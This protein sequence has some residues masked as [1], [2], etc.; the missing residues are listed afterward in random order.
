MEIS[1]FGS[2]EPESGRQNPSDHSAKIMA[3]DLF[4]V[5]MAMVF[6]AGG[7]SFAAVALAI[8]SHYLAAVLVAFL[9][10]IFWRAAYSNG[11]DAARLYADMPD[12]D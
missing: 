12:E 9:A 4:I 1:P 3:A 2:A 10:S 7:A 11:Q 8:H 5:C 6:V